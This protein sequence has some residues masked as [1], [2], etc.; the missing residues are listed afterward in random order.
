[1]AILEVLEPKLP[2]VKTIGNLPPIKW[3]MKKVYKMISL[4]RRV[5]VA[6]EVKEGGFD[7]APEFNVRYRF[8]FMLLFLLF[9]TIMLFPIHNYALGNSFIHTSSINLQIAHFAI[10]IMNITIAFTLRK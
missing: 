6:P 1:D 9:N 5:I 4:N 7:C 3:I 8:A 2:F 10:V